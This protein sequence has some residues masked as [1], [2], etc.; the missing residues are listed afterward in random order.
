MGQERAEG[1]AVA[2]DVEKW[3]GR[4][5]KKGLHRTPRGLEVPKYYVTVDTG[6]V[7]EFVEY[8]FV[9]A[10]F[11]YML[12]ANVLGV[13]VRDF[14][15]RPRHGKSTELHKKAYRIF[16]KAFGHI[17]VR[18]K[19][20]KP[21]SKYY[22]YGLILSDGH[23]MNKNTIR[24]GSSRQELIAIVLKT[25]KRTKIYIEY[26]VLLSKCVIHPTLRITVKNDYGT[27]EDILKELE[28]ATL[29][30]LF[31][32]IARL[33]DGDGNIHTKRHKNSCK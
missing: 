20:A 33:T 22:K 25:F 4:L 21:A 1:L 7:D 28:E 26:P 32:Y 5:K 29:T 24:F 9:R 2:V 19:N 15:K 14:A 13:G 16:S 30:Q 17:K 27:K 18:V 6:E 10:M 3:N 11:A 31:D 23:I 12:A 8:L